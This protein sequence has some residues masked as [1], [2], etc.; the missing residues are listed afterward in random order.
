MSN[1]S[2]EPADLSD[3][4]LRRRAVA[5]ARGDAP[6][7]VLIT[8][9][10]VVDV[11][12][13]E[14]RAAD[15]G[16]VGSLIASVHPPGT[17]DDA[18][19]VVDAAG[20]YL[21]PGLIDAHMHIES[22]M[23]TPGRYAEAVVPCG[24]TTI[25]WDPHELGNVGGEP[26]V[27][28]A[29]EN[30]RGL[31]LRVITQV[32]S[33]V[34]S[35]P[36]LE[37]SGA[38]FD[39]AAIARMLAWPEMGGLAEVM[40]MHD[41]IGGGER[42][43]GIVQAGL[44]SGK[45]VRGH[46]RG[47]AG[48]NL[49]AF[50]AAGVSSDHELTSGEDLLSKLRAGLA[51]EMRGS[52][53][54][55]LPGFVEAIKALG[56]LPPTVTLCTDDTFPDDLAERGGVNDVVRRLVRYGL[57]PIWTLRAAT[58]NAAIQLGRAD[59]GLIAPGRRADIVIF[60]D[61]VTFSA[62]HVIVSGIEVARDGRLLQA[63]NPDVS[64]GLEGTVK[65]G[66][67]VPVDFRVPSRAKRARVATIDNP[68]FTS[69]GE[70]HT[71]VDAG[72]VVPPAGSVLMA[73]ANRHGTG[74][75]RPRIGY[76]RNWGEWSGAFCTTVSHDSHNLTVFGSDPSDMALAANIVIDAGGGMAVVQDGQPLAVLALPLAGLLSP[77][78]VD[79]VGAGFAAIRQAMDRVV[80]WQPPMLVF[81]ACFGASLACNFGPHLTDQG[82]A[83]VET[84][85]LI[86]SPILEE[87]A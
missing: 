19:H 83:D 24:V 13:S 44:A 30:S 82:I 28:W 71:T 33:S 77:A 31:P 35:A 27:R 73:V 45:P 15:I 67:L 38:D 39:A 42:M 23:L 20:H 64:S 60:D 32:P 12:T 9:G 2:S 22:S 43:T 17:R 86:P 59:L 87:W 56:H 69:W 36:G 75:G 16:I 72:F 74:D 48:S 58:Y 79:V 51:I 26:A 80:T 62:R 1:R 85:R 40:N 54:Q 41:V 18:A 6:F 11:I 21:A 34:P 70:A 29:V 61:L 4:D 8:R 81:K 76:L 47:L 50:V 66:R 57:D 68:R 78:S 37:R 65:L 46:A 3:P 63:V 7:D 52:H 14:L 49:A 84:G 25:A 53:D 5:A 10:V 55:L